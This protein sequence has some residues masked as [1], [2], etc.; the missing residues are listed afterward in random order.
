M[1]SIK[2]GIMVTRAQD[3]NFLDSKPIYAEVPELSAAGLTPIEEKT[4]NDLAKIFA[5]KYSQCNSAENN[6]HEIF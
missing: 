6:I 4:M 3:G 1:H 2:I 5:D